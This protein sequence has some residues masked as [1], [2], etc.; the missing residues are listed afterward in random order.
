MPNQYKYNYT[1]EERIE[2]EERKRKELEQEQKH[3]EYL[4]G[5]VCLYGKS[6]IIKWWSNKL[7]KA[8]RRGHTDI[9]EMLKRDIEYVTA[10]D[11]SYELGGDKIIKRPV[12]PV[13]EYIPKPITRDWAWWEKEC[14]SNNSSDMFTVKIGEQK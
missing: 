3:K 13:V 5:Q 6:K 8:E 9:I 7:K 4:I 11:D 2:E 1:L 14:T 10:L 12:E